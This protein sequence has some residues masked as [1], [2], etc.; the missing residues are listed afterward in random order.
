[1]ITKLR[2]IKPAADKRA[3]IFI[4]GFIWICSGIMLLSFSYYWLHE[5]QNINYWLIAG[6]SFVLSLLIHH[7]GFLKIVDIN[8]R[9]LLPAKEKKCIFSFMDWKSYINVAVMAV[10][11]I[12]V[13]NSTIPKIYLSIVYAAIGFA[14]ILSSVRYMRI[15]FFHLGKNA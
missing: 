2:K 5:I 9:R 15:F 11:G 1:M 3:L 8:L 4:A 12:I 13:R 7:F 14:L 10:I 6:I